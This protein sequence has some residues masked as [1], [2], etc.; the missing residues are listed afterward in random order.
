MPEENNITIWAMSS[1]ENAALSTHLLKIAAKT[2]TASNVQNCLDFVTVQAALDTDKA[3][4]LCLIYTAPELILNQ[5]FQDGED[6]ARVLADWADAA[7]QMLSLHRHNRR[8]SLLF[9]AT[10]LRRYFNVGLTRLGLQ[11][12]NLTPDM[13]PQNHTINMP[14]LGLIAHGHLQNRREVAALREELDASAQLLSNDVVLVPPLSAELALQN[15]YALRLRLT[16]AEQSGEEAWGQNR[17]H[18]KNFEALKAEVVEAETR[19]RQRQTWF[20]HMRADS[21]SK[22]QESAIRIAT[23][24]ESQRQ[25]DAALSAHKKRLDDL[26][27]V[28]TNLKQ[29]RE[30]SETH[31][32]LLKA[33]NDR[34]AGSRSMRVTAPLRRLNKFLSRSSRG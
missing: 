29:A 32:R 20:D 9:E 25:A 10:H 27:Q 1:A 15:Y 14:L 6:P 31:V 12:G 19:L 18:L 23:L 3:A 17:A 21:E 34:I 22:L 7:R 13:P 16:E 11:T 4:R 28:S 26:T 24:E 30:K 33:E 8:R 5:A 2:E